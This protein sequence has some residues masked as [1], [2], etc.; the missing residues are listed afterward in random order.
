[1][2]CEGK[3]AKD[4]LGARSTNGVQGMTVVSSFGRCQACEACESVSRYGLVAGYLWYWYCIEKG[5]GYGGTVRL[6]VGKGRIPCS[7]NRLG[8][9]HQ[10]AFS[11]VYLKV[12]T[13]C[14]YAG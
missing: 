1:M 8:F 9:R 4:N 3:D 2:T 13:V 11:T 14:V 6:S 12:C 7:H 10:L 5:K